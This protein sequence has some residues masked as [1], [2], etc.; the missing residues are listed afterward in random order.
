MIKQRKSPR[1]RKFIAPVC[2]F[3][4]FFLAGIAA[5]SVRAQKS[6]A[7]RARVLDNRIMCMCGGCSD[8]AAKCNHMGGAF[9]GPCETAQKE[10]AEVAQRVASG[11]SDSLILQSFVQEYGPTVLI[12]PPA[13]GFDLWAWIMPIIAALAGIALALLFIARWHRRHAT[14][15]APRVNPELLAR[16]QHEMH[17][18]F[19]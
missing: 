13:R 16:V 18:E 12:S 7:E 3:G 2:A 9:A 8:A 1:T 19:D 17:G 10:M 6:P 14:A 5:L 11:Q 4:I 15:P